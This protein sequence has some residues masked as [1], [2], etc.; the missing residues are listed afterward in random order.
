MAKKNYKNKNSQP[1]KVPTFIAALLVL[2]VLAA[3]PFGYI[4]R[5][6]IANGVTSG[7]NTVVSWF[8]PAEET[9][10]DGE[11]LPDDGTETPDEGG[12][13]TPDEG[14]DEGAETPNVEG[15]ETPDNGEDSSS[16]E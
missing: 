16:I 10:A 13:V 4:F 12:E 7:W 14:A 5:A 15:D 9:P 8:T 1:A 3:I 6:E 2:V 11:Q